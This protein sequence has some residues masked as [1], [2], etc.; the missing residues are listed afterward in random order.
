MKPARTAARKAAKQSGAPD[1]RA[2]PVTVR[3]QLLHDPD[4]PMI[5]SNFFEVSHSPHDFLLLLA[6][7]PGKLPAGSEP[8]KDGVTELPI[9]AQAQIVIPPTVI[10]GLIKALQSQQ[11]LFEELHGKI[12]T[13]ENAGE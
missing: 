3:V 7:V 4:A 11:R 1:E 6:R 5:Y 8:N 9:E 12:R 10:P 2:Q 13:S